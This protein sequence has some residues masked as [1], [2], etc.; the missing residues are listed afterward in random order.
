MRHTH[1]QNEK[2]KKK[3]KKEREGVE[4]NEKRFV[5]SQYKMVYVYVI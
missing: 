4:K 5:V 2:K 1:I 3:G